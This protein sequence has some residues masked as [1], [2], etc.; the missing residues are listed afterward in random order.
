MAIV[1][2][3]FIGNQ[4]EHGVMRICDCC[5]VDLKRIRNPLVIF[6]SSGDNITPPQ[7]ALNWIPTV[8]PTTAAL[9]QAGQRIVYLLN[10]HVGHLGIFVSAKVAKLEHRAILE[11]LG[12]LE[13]LPPGLYEMKISNPTGDPDCRKPQ[14]SV[15]FEE[16]EVEQI[17]YPYPQQAFEKV[18]VVSEWNAFLYQQLLSPWITAFA[19]PLSA[20]MLNRLH[21]M[22]LK[23]AL[24]SD[25]LNPWM[26]GI[27]M[28]A[29]WVASARMPADDGNP[30]VA[31]EG[32]AGRAV[33]N[34]LDSYRRLR[35]A[36]SESLFSMLY[37]GSTG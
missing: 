20:R 26:I 32:E 11:S 16:R 28:L 25:K 7:Q 23:H 33:S 9:K 34:A 22:R 5:Y 35:D 4:V 15:H 18:R 27:K 14:Y 37:G 29:P 1:E 12:D 19:T 6:A 13:V 24:F 8:Y 2:N 17:H 10:A 30:L 31:V 21:P 3:L 36:A